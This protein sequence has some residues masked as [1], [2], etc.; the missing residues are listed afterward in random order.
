MER[1]KTRVTKLLLGLVLN[2]IGWKSG[3][4]FL[5]QSHNEIKQMQSKC[6]AI[7]N[8]LGHSSYVNQYNQYN[9]QYSTTLFSVQQEMR[10]SD[11]LLPMVADLLKH[12]YFL[13]LG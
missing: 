3:A 4:S 7:P 12:F 6:K 5:E 10:I 2:F 8:Y 11:I 13:C 1:G 9:N